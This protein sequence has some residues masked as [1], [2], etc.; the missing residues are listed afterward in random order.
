MTGSLRWVIW[1]I[2]VD[3]SRSSPSEPTSLKNTGKYASS[4][5]IRLKASRDVGVQQ[6]RDVAL[7][8]VGVGTNTPSRWR[9]ITSADSSCSYLI[10]SLSMIASQVRRHGR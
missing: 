6:R 1:S 4:C 8:E 3:T 9:L 7:E 10:G 2:R 5:M